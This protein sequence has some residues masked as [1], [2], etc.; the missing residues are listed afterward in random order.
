M[1][2]VTEVENQ[3]LGLQLRHPLHQH[4]ESVKKVYGELDD[5]LCLFGYIL[6]EMATGFESPTPSPLD[7]L[8]E[9]PRKLDA[10][11]LSILGRVFGDKSLGNNPTIADLI[12]D[13]F[14]NATNVPQGDATLFTSL[15]DENKT[16]NMM[17]NAILN[18]CYYTYSSEA[19]LGKKTVSKGKEEK[20]KKKKKKKKRK[21][22]KEKTENIN[23]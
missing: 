15:K 20:D 14:F 17:I 4:L 16:V 1:G 10:N 21:K 2:K 9:M 13:P 6:F 12:N 19:L 23:I 22:R 11:I 7:C 5:R 18:Q 8:H 3:L